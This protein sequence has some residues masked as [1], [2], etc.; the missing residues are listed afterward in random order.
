V[1]ALYKS[2]RTAFPDFHADIH[3]QGAAGE[4]VTTYRTYHGTHKGDIFGI[5]PTGKAIQFE[6][7]DVMRVRNGKITDH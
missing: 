4:L 1:R 6:T 5:V 7:V 3:W 2:I